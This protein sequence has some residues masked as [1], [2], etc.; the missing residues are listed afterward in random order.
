M[1]RLRYFVSIFS[2]LIFSA[3][4][5]WPG[6][7]RPDS[8]IQMNQG[9][10]GSFSDHHP[11]IMSFVWGILNHIK[12]GS[13][14]MLLLHLS[15]YW[16]AV[17]LYIT[18]SVKNN[19]WFLICAILPPVICYQPFILKDIAFVNAFLFAS[20][21]LYKHNN[22]IQ[23]PSIFSITIFCLIV[24]YGAAS[25]YQAIFAMPWLCFWFAKIYW[26]NSNWKL[27][28]IFIYLVFLTSIKIFNTTTSQPSHSW[29]YVK[30]YDMAGIAVELNQDIFPECIKKKNHYSFEKVKSL[31]NPRRVD[32]MAFNADSPLT[33]TESKNERKIVWNTW[34]SIITKN[35]LTYLKHRSKVFHQQLT[36]SFLKKTDDI[37]SETKSSIINIVK[38]IEKSGIFEI[39]QIF[40]AGFIYF[41]GQILYTIYGLKNFNKSKN[42]QALFFQNITG[43]S[44]M[45]SLFIFSMASEARYAYLCIAL[46]NFSHPFLLNI[47]QESP[48][49]FN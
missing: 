3:T 36:V 13:G 34:F 6:I 43:F 16:G 14:P 47:K 20:A 31:Y 32:D 4:I 18:A 27:K 45:C 8:I 37:K 29:Q 17:Y 38:I 41:I 44:L 21:W 1:N 25:K 42:M 23:K 10:S 39:L 28:G 48:R 15:L 49:I 19:F 24:F 5:F 9:I 30:I 7:L 12:Q 40:M 2:L 26:P 11:P 22:Q 46:F 33:K 35:P